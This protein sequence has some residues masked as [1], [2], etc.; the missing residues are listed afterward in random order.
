MKRHAEMIRYSAVALFTASVLALA[1]C[2]G[3]GGGSGGGEGTSSGTLK[4]GHGGAP[5]DVLT[6]SVD[7]LNELI[8]EG[9]DGRW[10]VE[11]YGASQLGNERDLVEGVSMGTVDMTLVTNA[12]LGNFVS[13]ALFYDLPGLYRDLDHV[14]AVAESPLIDDHLAPALLEKNLRLL[15]VTDGGFRNITNS[16]GP[17]STLT[18]LEGIKMRVQESPM[19]MAT[20]DAIPGV[21]PVPVPIGDL[22]TSLDQG[23]VDAQENPAILVRDFKFYEVQSY[24]TLTQH[25]YFPRHFL[26]NESVWESLSDEDRKVF[27]EAIA[28]VVTFKNDYYATE[29]QNALD[30]LEAAGMNINE[31]GEAFSS[32]LAELMRA[33]VYSQFYEDIGGGDAKKGEEIIQQIIDLGN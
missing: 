32:D 16:R 33:E 19:I 27:E 31:P 25:S 10:S 23:I 18:D 3:D 9:T 7:L 14:H 20:Y 28:Q 6:Q 24:M 1:G 29:N 12:P 4:L 5:G 11:N 21:S 22:Y 26:V 2:A 15:G 30:E 8:Q 17:I 13:E